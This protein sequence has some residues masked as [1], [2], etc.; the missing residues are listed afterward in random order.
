MKRKKTFQQL[1][2]QE[3]KQ[4]LPKILST[5]KSNFRHRDR[6]IHKGRVGTR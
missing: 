5:P 3:L 2:L 1:N 6:G 4:Q